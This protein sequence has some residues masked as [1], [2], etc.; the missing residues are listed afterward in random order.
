MGVYRWLVLCLVSFILV[1]WVYLSTGSTSLP[2]WGEAAAL[3][4]EI[5]LPHVVIRLLL[6]N[7]QQSRSLLQSVG[8]DLQFVEV[9]T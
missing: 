6:I 3:A 7:V 8:L 2:D 4:L 1:H 9:K 5:L